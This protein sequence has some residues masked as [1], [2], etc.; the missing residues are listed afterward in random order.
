MFS[1]PKYKTIESI[2]GTSK[3]YISF[4]QGTVRI[5][6]TPSPI[7]RH[8][9]EKLESDAL[10]YYQYVG[11]IYPLRT[12]LAEKN[13]VKPE[14]VVISHGSIGGITAICLTLLKTG[15]EV[16]VPAPYYPSYRNIILFSKAVPVY[17]EAY[18]RERGRWV[19]DL[20][21]VKN[22]TTSKTKMIILSNPSNPTGALLTMREVN[23]L[24]QWCEEKGIYLV[25]DE[26]YDNYIYEGDFHS[27]TPHVSRSEHVLRTGSFSKDYA[28]SG[29]RVGYII[30][31]E[32]LVPSLI[33]VQ[34][35]TLCCPSV[36]GQCAALYALENEHLI[37]EQ[38]EAVQ[39]NRDIVF[40]HLS[41]LKGVF[42]FDKPQ[43]GIFYFLQTT[44]DDSEE[45]VMD[46]L[47][48]VKVALVPG[49]DFGPNAAP[50][51]RLCF[52]RQEAILIAGLD[53]L[54]KLLI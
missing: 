43:A 45:L 10:D 51:I 44:R 39:R 33:A 50:F 28:M 40:E 20:E 47:H 6:G 1:L 14:Q 21:S 49:K 17:A 48:K 15:D 37:A 41:L 32:S 2:S 16:I 34:D 18:R 19:F 54:L 4:S 27:F 25:S 23:D 38:T 30:A 13:G 26:V 5:A 35:G 22:C 46:I 8:L 24:K 52:A 42:S 31:P 9:M 53:R 29:W 36:A 12:K 7:K 11:G 3:E